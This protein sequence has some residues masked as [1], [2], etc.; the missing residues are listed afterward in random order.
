MPAGAENT[1]GLDE[2][3]A[4]GRP[5]RFVTGGA[6]ADWR[7]ALSPQERDWAEV[8]RFEALGGQ[9]LALPDAA[10]GLAGAVGGLGDAEDPLSYAHLPASL[11]AARFA[12]AEGLRPAVADALALGWALGAAGPLDRPARLVWPK[13]CQRERIA[14]LIAAEIDARSW[15]NAPP[16][17][18]GPGELAD[19]ARTELAGQGAEVRVLSGERLDEAGYPGLAHVG[20]GA[21]RPPVLVDATWGSADAPRLT[22]VGKGVCFDAGGLNA[23][24]YPD[25]LAM[26]ADMAGAAH[27]LALA[28][29]VI[30]RRLPVRLRLLI[31]AADNMPSG[32][33]MMNGDLVR[34]ACGQTI[35]VVHTDYEGRVMLADALAAA[36]AEAPD[37]LIDFSTLTDTGLGPDIAGVFTQD[38]ALA[39]ELAAHAARL[40]DPVWRL[41]LWEGYAGQIRTRSGHLA[42]RE[43]GEAR[44]ASIAAALF[45][46]RF[47]R[48]AGS[49]L[50]FDLEGWNAIACSPRPFGGNVVG[51]RA[52]LALLESRYG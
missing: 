4:G 39:E 23:K 17:E 51:L 19:L 33:A 46:K 20:R 49:W 24:P 8:C 45:L 5:L 41:P 16:C 48:Q 27:A 30:A 7:A 37:L 1:W 15:I 50:H 25:V 21:A 10:G 32:S 35:E 43:T 31:A 26:K 14:P 18:L 3:G 29:L 28:R 2:P 34:T 13:D 9:T 40:R 52:T 6:H 11:P 36:D 47:V 12:I 42:N 22:L 38:D 44:I